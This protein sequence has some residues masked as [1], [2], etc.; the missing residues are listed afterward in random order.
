MQL[1][2]ESYAAEAP[3][4]VGQFL[5]NRKLAKYFNR[6][7][8]AA[9]IAARKLLDLHP[10]PA[11]TPFYYETGIMEFESLGLDAISEGSRNADG[12]FDQRNFVEIGAKAVPPLTQFKALY[13]MPLSFVAI[14]HGLVGDNAVIYASANG[15]LMQALNAPGEGD[16][17]LGCGKVHADASVDS[18][19]ALV[20]RQDLAEAAARNWPGEAIELFRFWRTPEANA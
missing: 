5:R 15:L 8:A 1:I 17:L 20:N 7:T 6:E 12:S 14:E 2:F 4:P 13:N 9:L 19:F 10:C 3:I 16:V 18:A 11:N